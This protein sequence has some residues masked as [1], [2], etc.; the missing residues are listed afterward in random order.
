VVGGLV[1]HLI[2]RHDAGD[3]FNRYSW[4]APAAAIALASAI[5]ITAPRTA[6]SSVAV[7]DAEALQIVTRHC[8]NCHARR[9]THPGFAEPP[10]RMRLETL[11]DVRQHARLVRAQAVLSNAMPLGNETR[12][13]ADERMKLGAWLAAAR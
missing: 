9:P 2:N 11:A 6:T 8:A 7:A 13:T 1:R 12:M 5:T 3:D 4:A 10:K